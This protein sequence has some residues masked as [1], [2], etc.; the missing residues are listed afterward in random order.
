MEWTWMKLPIHGNAAWYLVSFV[1][2]V[3]FLATSTSYHAFPR[4]LPWVL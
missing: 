4:A 3:G 2:P 1:F